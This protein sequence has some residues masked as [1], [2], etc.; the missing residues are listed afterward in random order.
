M[1]GILA[2]WALRERS[3]AI[4]RKE[5]IEMQNEQIK[6]QLNKSITLSKNLDDQLGK[7]VEKEKVLEEVL[8]L[9]KN[10]YRVIEN[11]NKEINQLGVTVDALKERID[12]KDKTQEQIERRAKAN[13]LLTE[14]L[15]KAEY[16]PNYAI[17]LAE[18]ANQ[19]YPS[20]NAQTTIESIYRGYFMKNYPINRNI[21]L[22]ENAKNLLKTNKIPQLSERQKQ[23]LGITQ[24]EK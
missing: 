17:R 12:E 6:L 22:Y 8:R 7:L 5:E 1:L 10:T 2:G 13:E 23:E 16:N 14:A 20:R 9:D 21:S 19:I 18:M 24:F 3:I 15:L 11:K 4:D